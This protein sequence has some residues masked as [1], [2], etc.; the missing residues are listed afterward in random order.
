VAEPSWLAGLLAAV[1][2][3]TAA[4]CAVRLAVAWRR[5][6]PT[7]YDVDAAHV[8][9]GVAMAGMLVPRLNPFGD[10]G[11]RVIFGGAAAWFA[12]RAVRQY[13][14]PRA[15]WPRARRPRAEWRRTGRRVYHGHY[16]HHV[17]ASGAMLYMFAYAAGSA[18]A[19]PGLPM[20]GSSM[21]GMPGTAEVA[22]SSP[23]AAGFPSLTLGLALALFAGVIWAVD[24]TLA[25]PIPAPVPVPTT[26]ATAGN[27]V[28]AARNEAGP[29]RNPLGP[30]DNPAAPLRPAMSPRLAACCE[31][32]MGVTM[33]YMLITML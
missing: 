12:V 10:A 14:G 23:A 18:G 27:P 20:V 30:A 11:W 25:W 8:L 1:M 21:P 5:R 33:S 32:V 4:Y 15:E 29:D 22:G 16:L 13:L 9:M 6:R 26:A 19:A 7:A 2:I 31:I 28:A 24:R 17:L 3:A